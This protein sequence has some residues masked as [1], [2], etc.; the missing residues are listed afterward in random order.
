MGPTG[1]AA[2]GTV[3]PDTAIRVVGLAELLGRLSLRR[4]CRITP[5][6]GL[7]LMTRLARRVGGNLPPCWFGIELPGPGGC[8][9]LRWSVICCVTLC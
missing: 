4:L 3:G 1:G 2:D 8:E 5:V 7:L 9:Y 6:V